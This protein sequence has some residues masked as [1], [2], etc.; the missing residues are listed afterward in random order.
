MKK[1][2]RLGWKLLGLA[3]FALLMVV[4]YIYDL[5]CIFRYLTGI[6]CFTCGMSRAWLLALRLELA[7][8]FCMH[9]LFWTIP[10]F[11]IFMIFDGKVF[12]GRRINTVLPLSL[13]AGLFLVYFVRLFGFLGALSPL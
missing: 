8:A 12:P 5:P 1:P 4:W 10:V 2:Q 13:L 3:A 6:P 11:V 7:D 9:P